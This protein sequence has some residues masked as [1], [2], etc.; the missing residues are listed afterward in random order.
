MNAANPNLD[1]RLLRRRKALVGGM[2][3]MTVLAL[4]AVICGAW[5]FLQQMETYL[6]EEMGRRLLSVATLTAKIIE[7]TDFPFFV[8]SERF[9]LIMPLLRDVL[10]SV[11]GENQL[12]GVYLVDDNYKVFASSRNIFPFG[13]RLTFLEDDSL[14]VAQAASGLPAVA[15]MQLLE[16]N[17]FKSA[18][19]PVLGPLRDV[20]AIVVVQASADFFDLLRVFQRGLIV[21]GLIGVAVAG[22]LSAVLFWAITLLVKTH[23]SLRQSERLAA[24]GQMAATVAHE[25]RNPLGI[26]KGTADVLNSKYNS[27]EQPDELFDFIPSEVRRLNRLVSDFLTFARDRE[28][29]PLAND[30][31]NTVKKSL[32][33][34]EDELRQAN[35][36]LQAE[37]EN[38]PPVKHDEDAINQVLLNLT[39]NGMQAMNGGGEMSVRV[40]PDSRKGRALA[41]LEVQDSGCGIDGNLDQIFEPFFTTKTNGSGLGLAICRR[42]VE[43]HG[44]WMEVESEKNKGTTMR[45]YLPAGL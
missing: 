7:S 17:R 13:E 4:F 3:V 41:R 44:G 38:L 35:I 42:L 30:L 26:I 14:I 32:S 18:Y 12:Q 27:K 39:L 28:I 16:G 25:I 34:V 24:M 43:K 5:N 23:E 45:V 40:K 22:L 21:G 36:K 19:A 8:E 29:Q 11:H 1:E 6:E 31:L 10:N 9:S 37:F 15:P 33:S 20:A 2:I